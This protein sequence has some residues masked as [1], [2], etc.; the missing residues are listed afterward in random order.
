MSAMGRAFGNQTGRGD[1]SISRRRVAIASLMIIA[2]TVVI[3]TSCGGL[4]DTDVDRG[5][6]ALVDAFS[7][8]R[9]IE[10]RLSGGFKAGEF[11]PS[12][13]DTPGIRTDAFE[14]ASA[15]IMDS[16]AKGDL[17]AQLPYARLLLS[18]NEKLPEAL[19]Y[20]RL[21]LARAPESAEAHNDLGVCFVQQG[22]LED[23]IS[24][25]DIALKQRNDMPEALFNRALS[26]QLLL[27]EEPARKDFTRGA[28]VERDNG[29]LI[30]IRR[31]IEERSNSPASQD[32]AQD[33]VAEFKAAF[34]DGRLEDAKK[35]AGDN[36]EPLRTHALRELT[37]L[38]LRSAADGDIK[39][40]EHALSEI[41]LIGDALIEKMGDS[42]TR[43]VGAYLAGVPESARR[44]ELGLIDEY[45]ETSKGARITNEPGTVFERL[46]REFRA[47]GNYVFEALSA[48][49]VADQFYD[50]KLFKES[51]E[52][53]KRLLSS[54]ATRE[55]PY[56]RARFLNELALETSRVGQDSLAIKYF[57][58]AI[59]RCSE[60]PDLEFK[61][62]QYMSVPYNQ[63]GDIDGALDRL[64][65]STKSALQNGRLPNRLSN[66][67]YNYSQLAGIYSLRNLHSLALP[68]AQQA[69]SYAEQAKNFEYAAEYSS[70]VAVEEARLGQ[71][72]A[73][74]ANL[75]RALEYLEPIQ[76]TKKRGLAEA[77]VL[78]KAIEVAA[79]RGDAQ[80][81]VAYYTRAEDLAKLDEGNSLLKIDLL[82]A[83]ANAYIA[84]GE[85]GNARSDLL[86]A[87][88]EIE[89]YRANI[90]ASDQRSHFLDASHD[91]FDQLISLDVGALDK[92]PEAFEMAERSRAR[93][94]LEEISN[95][96]KA[97]EP[98]NAAHFSQNTGASNLPASVAPLSLSEVRS[99]L[100][101]DLTILE[102]AITSE[103][104]YLFLITRSAFKVKETS[105]TTEALQRITSE[106]IGGLRSLAAIKEV[107]EKASE[108]Y[109]LLIRPVE[110]E[111]A[112][113]VNLCIV[114]DKALHFL[115]FAGLV[116]GS[117]HYL[118]ESRRLSYAPSASV[119]I[120]CLKERQP[121]A[122]GKP[123][124]LLAVGNPRFNAEYFPNLRPLQDAERE[125]GQSAKFYAPASV[126]L[127]GEE[128]TEPRV[129]SAIKE[130][131]V[132][133]LAVHCLV[134]ESSP[135]L[136]A[137]VLAAP[138][139]NQT[140][141]HSGGAV[142]S[143]APLANPKTNGTILRSAALTRALPPE[144]VIDPNDG[145]LYLSELYGMKLS[146][147]R[148]VVLSA[149]QSGLGQ[150]YRGEGIVSLVRPLLAAGVTTVVA[151]LWPVD[152][153]AT[154]DLMIEFHKQRKLN[155][156]MQGAEALRRA[157]IEL[158]G[159]YEHPFYWAP[160]IAVGGSSSPN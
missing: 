102:Y 139:V 31:R 143:P 69:L 116:D 126:T 84:S 124:N 57:E 81:A 94:L 52:K 154:S 67:A 3:E 89:R 60:S 61:I 43:D 83:R 47:R 117:Q 2:L 21:V 39:R 48:F 129:R 100:P 40:A 150:Y 144:P 128:A 70:F 82:R 71:F 145:L 77:R 95:S 115:P 18:R 11:R 85:S 4:G 41:K 88:S 108:L 1:A 26:Y 73:A 96:A 105:T 103:G 65:D 55:W 15:L 19:K 159:T 16:L 46:E 50:S 30:E 147:T 49:R 152:S 160:F 5:Q 111:I 119:L 127:I 122:R 87:V 36:S 148:L 113:V 14:K 131:D 32:A 10:A 51:M 72:E 13:E 134:D 90:G 133:H 86:L 56:D 78:T 149:C 23:A 53:I 27:L 156:G 112:G 99:N 106:Y 42:I 37:R 137:L 107:N 66:L 138:K 92:A 80:R 93:A 38:Y 141:V 120:Q 158:A 157:Q 121:T 79:R 76:E 97:A 118:L 75:K 135:W 29:W 110:S 130:C 98:K 63:I 8:R 22:K 68:Y 146:R 136:A 6:R 12:P 132:A 25:F 153:K 58:Q 35:L 104:T 33:P 101:D 140:S 125:A 24:E 44:T 142:A 155:V 7:T 74:E 28:E 59:T 54:T 123:E 109:D 45:V 20:L 114:P 64:R 17:S 151:S 91:V 9:L 62:L 34:D